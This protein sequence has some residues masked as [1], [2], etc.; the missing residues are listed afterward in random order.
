M[1]VPRRGESIVLPD[2]LIV[3]AC[4]LS[5]KASGGG[6]S[7]RMEM[8]PDTRLAPLRK[9]RRDVVDW[10]LRRL[11]RKS[12]REAESKKRHSF[13]ESHTRWHETVRR[14]CAARRAGAL[15]RGALGDGRKSDEIDSERSTASKSP[16]YFLFVTGDNSR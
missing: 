9:R 14:R 5:T 8:C 13:T 11:V 15:E 2:C 12:V 4:S 7:R 6:L 3:V 16:L 1:L 10:G